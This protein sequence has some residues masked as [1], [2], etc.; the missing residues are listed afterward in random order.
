MVDR[1]AEVMVRLHF[2]RD[3]KRGALVEAEDVLRVLRAREKQRTRIDRGVD[4]PVADYRVFRH[5]GYWVDLRF[6]RLMF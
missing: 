3:L 1:F 2:E 6:D 5:P 4:V